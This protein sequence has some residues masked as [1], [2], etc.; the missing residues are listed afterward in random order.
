M[1]EPA[2]YERVRDTLVE[3][4][5]ALTDPQGRPIG[6]RVYKPQAIYREYRGV[7]PDLIVYFGDLA[8]RSLGSVGLGSIYTFENDTGPDD[9]NHAQFGMFIYYDPRQKG[10]GRIPAL[11]LT[12]I[13]P[14]LLEFL[15]V[16]IPSDMIGRVPDFVKR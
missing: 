1:I 11:H 16:P 9:A 4:L 6:T 3:K 2:S 8:W 13:G 14:S 10:K 15:E 12:D 5:E 7:P